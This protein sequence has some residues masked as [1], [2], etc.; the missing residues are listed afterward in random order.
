MNCAFVLAYKAII[1][2]KKYMAW[3]AR[4]IL[5]KLFAMQTHMSACTGI[6]EDMTH[7]CGFRIR[8]DSRSSMS[9]PEM[10][11]TG[12]STVAG[13]WRVLRCDKCSR[14]RDWRVLLNW[15]RRESRAVW[16]DSKN[17]RLTSGGRR[18]L[19][20]WEH[21]GRAQTVLE[22]RGSFEATIHIVALKTTKGANRA[23]MDS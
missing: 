11:R 19:R 18:T 1:V 4:E 10:I 21:W 20:R 8:R 13:T 7:Y 2:L 9:H 16:F 3:G 23:R 17:H 6:N 12:A 5:C 22:I 15:R 14:R